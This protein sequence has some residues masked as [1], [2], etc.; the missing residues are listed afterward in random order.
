MANKKKGEN[1]GKNPLN[2][3]N[4]PYD[5]MVKKEKEW[6]FANHFRRIELK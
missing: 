3:P 1:D 5:K 4:Y 6:H 2:K